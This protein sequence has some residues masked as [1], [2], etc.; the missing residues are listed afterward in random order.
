METTYRKY[1]PEEVKKAQE[2]TTNHYRAS[3]AK[4]GHKYPNYQSQDSNHLN[5]PNIGYQY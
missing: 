3:I 4:D 1:T 2:E 5:N